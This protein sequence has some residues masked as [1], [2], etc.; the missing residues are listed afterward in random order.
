MKFMGYFTIK[1]RLLAMV[2]ISILLFIGFSI[3]ANFSVRQVGGL[4]NTIYDHPFKVTTAALS[5]ES[6]ISEMHNSM[7]K[8]LAYTDN[9]QLQLDI[10]KIQVEQSELYTDLDI[11]KVNILGDK[12]IQLEKD[13]RGLIEKLPLIKDH[14]LSLI[15]KG[16]GDEAKKYLLGTEAKVVQDIISKLTEIQK[17]SETTASMYRIDANEKKTNNINIMLLLIVSIV[18]IKFVT[19][20]FT[21]K[22]IQK[23]LQPLKKA[24]E[25][26]ASSN[27]FLTVELIG[28]NEI[29]DIGKEYNRLINVLKN[30]LEFKDGQNKLSGILTG[31][32]NVN[33]FAE[34]TITF[35]ARYFNAGSGV[36]FIYQED[37]QLLRLISSYAYTERD[38]LSNSFALGEGIIGQV[39]LEKKPIL[40]K[41]IKRGNIQIT[42]GTIVETPLNIY[43]FPLIYEEQ[44]YGVVELSAF[45]PFDSNKQNMIN[46]LSNIIATNL[47]SVLQSEK[48]RMLLK[49]TQETNAVMEEQ[50]TML[51]QQ[52]QEMTR[53]NLQLQE[54]LEKSQQQSEELQAQQEELRHTNK[55]LEEQTNDIADK[56]EDLKIAQ[57]E[58]EEKARALEISSQYK[59][60]FLANMSHEFRTPLNSIIVLSRLLANK[61]VNTL[62]TEKQLELAETIN[63]SGKDLLNLINDVLDLAKVEAGKIDVMLEK[64]DLKGMFG[65][66]EKQ[67]SP[68]ATEKGLFYRTQI[69]ED[70]SKFITT[71]GYRL[72]QII[73]NLLSNSFKFT[74]HGGITIKA[75]SVNPNT[76]KEYEMK[77]NDKYISI[78]VTDTGIGISEDKKEIIFEAF[79]QVD[80]SISRKFGGTGLGLTITR[81]LTEKLGGK[82]VVNSEKGVGSTFILIIPQDLKMGSE[83]DNHKNIGTPVDNT[84]EGAETRIEKQEKTEENQEKAIIMDVKQDKEKMLEGKKILIVDDDM[85]NVFALTSL[86]EENGLSVIIGKN[87]KECLEKLK[88]IPD[89]DLVLMDIMMPELDGYATMIEIRKVEE[90]KNIPIIALTA[91]AMK[92]D[93]SK[94]IDA[95]AND[96]LTKPIDIDKLISL[97]KLWLYK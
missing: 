96:Y 43:I 52:T 31:N 62:Y 46:E 2:T 80:G 42:T 61:E 18:F 71:D 53:K 5:E 33:V 16:K 68:I 84:K 91:K 25:E 11:I 44:L 75:S 70:V 40:L 49:D 10:S 22:S 93:R 55:E 37:D 56:N 45:E 72:Q 54:L 50:Q 66:I 3:F 12:G 17:Y 67:M 81:E 59:S 65:E 85:R 57:M 63:S 48:I 30:E 38:D 51:E 4:V 35:L 97:I 74:D 26:A 90:V 20:L 19:F 69:D 77:D 78:S 95:G 6:K 1:Q 89:V 8:Y 39:A 9:A 27:N 36:F 82:I 92:G 15:L 32:T 87:G 60:E 94:C 21:T 86:L 83:I 79:S 14:Y 13:V 73:K 23:S 7:L 88:E 76:L 29:N 41:N 58:I 28:N 47:F 64:I 24:V 34:N